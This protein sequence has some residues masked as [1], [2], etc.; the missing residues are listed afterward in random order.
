MKPTHIFMPQPLIDR[1][2]ALQEK[3]GLGFAEICRRALDE[4]LKRVKP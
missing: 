4:Y 2:K 1:I 3:T